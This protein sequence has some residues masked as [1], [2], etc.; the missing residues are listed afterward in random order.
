M[1]KEVS[2]LTTV[3]QAEIEA[4]AAMLEDRIDTQAVPEQRDWRDAERGVFYRPIKRQLTLRLDTDV[5]E[6]FKTHAAAG[7]GYQTSINRALRA[8]MARHGDT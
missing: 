4:L 6:W 2:K 3:Q 8:H 7:E 5:I 1:R